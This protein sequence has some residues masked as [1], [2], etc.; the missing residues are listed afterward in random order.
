MISVRRDV[1]YNIVIEFGV[2]MKLVRLMKMC[3]SETYS[4]VSIGN[5]LSDMFQFRMV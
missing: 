3:L 1:L 4:K 2:H 5:H